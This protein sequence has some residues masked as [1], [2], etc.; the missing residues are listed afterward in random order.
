MVR[1]PTNKL[2]NEEWPIPESLAKCETMRIVNMSAQ[3][4]EVPISW[5]YVPI[6]HFPRVEQMFAQPLPV[7]PEPAIIAPC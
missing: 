1:R 4:L 2:H 5:A 6:P 3:M 7:H